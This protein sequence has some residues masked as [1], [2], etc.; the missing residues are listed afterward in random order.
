MRYKERCLRQRYSQS[1]CRWD[2]ERGGG[3]EG[4]G[5]EGGGGGVGGDSDGSEGCDV[6]S[7]CQ[8]RRG[9]SEGGPS[10][11]VREGEGSRVEGWGDGS[12]QSLLL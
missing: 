9:G 3:D 5:N 1:Q 12:S 4:E 7:E 6:R 8:V 11:M 2:T 10:C